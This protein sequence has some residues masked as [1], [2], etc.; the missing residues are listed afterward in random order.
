MCMIFQSENIS[1]KQM[2]IEKQIFFV[3]KSQTDSVTFK[4]ITR[5]MRF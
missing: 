3:S 1:E 4:V 2:H 5:I